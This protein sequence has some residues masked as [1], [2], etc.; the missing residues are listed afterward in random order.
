MID[1]SDI[2][3]DIPIEVHD[4]STLNLQ[5]FK[6]LIRSSQISS[7]I[8]K[9]LMSAHIQ[10]DQP[11]EILECVLDFN[12][13]LQ[14][15]KADLPVELRPQD[16]V[17]QFQKRPS[18]RSLSTTLLQSSYYDLLMVSHAPFVYPWIT[19]RFER[20]ASPDVRAKISD[21]VIKSV[22]ATVVAARNIIVMTRNFEINGANTHA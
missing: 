8:C 18:Q 7:R 15:W 13:Q 22:E 11:A 19:Q 3:C 14:S 4:G 16:H 10:D 2:G 20:G 1:D 9:K 12:H 17:Q 5:V 21:Q 6:F